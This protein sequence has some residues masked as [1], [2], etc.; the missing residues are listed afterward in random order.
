MNVREQASIIENKI[1]NA[2]AQAG[3]NDEPLK[4]E[5][6]NQPAKPPV[7]ADPALDNTQQAVPAPGQAEFNISDYVEGDRLALE[8]DEH[9]N[10]EGMDQMGTKLTQ[11]T[12]GTTIIESENSRI[13]VSPDGHATI[14]SDNQESRYDLTRLPQSVEKNGAT[15]YELPDGGKITRKVDVNGNFSGFVIAPRDQ[16]A[17]ETYF[18]DH[19]VLYGRSLRK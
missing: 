15:T 18:G 4:P 11:R 17:L 13:K 1:K 10:L 6:A 16:Q 12:N 9:G 7:E 14:T 19:H 2:A 3:F 8:R 5:T